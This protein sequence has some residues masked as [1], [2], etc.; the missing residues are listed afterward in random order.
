MEKYIDDKKLSDTLGDKLSLKTQNGTERYKVLD[1][2][3]LSNG[4]TFIQKQSEIIEMITLC[5]FK[6][7]ELQ[8]EVDYLKR[9]N[10]KLEQLIKEVLEIEVSE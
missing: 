1:E 10:K 2:V 6:I 3:K 4:T 8:G 5:E 9:K 7:D